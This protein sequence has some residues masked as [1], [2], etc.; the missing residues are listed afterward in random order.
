MGDDDDRR[1]SDDNG[2][3]ESGME[4]DQG[5]EG[6]LTPPA[7]PNTPPPLKFELPPLPPPIEGSPLLNTHMYT[8]YVENGDASSKRLRVDVALG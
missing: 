8:N 6:G 4:V 1:C 7:R 2:G 3:Y 5:L